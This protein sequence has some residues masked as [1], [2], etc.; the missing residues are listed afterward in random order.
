MKL[1]YHYRLRDISFHDWEKLAR[2]VRMD[3]DR[4]FARTNAMIAVAMMGFL[5]ATLDAQRVP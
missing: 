4:L 1:G 3:S 2:A 5:W